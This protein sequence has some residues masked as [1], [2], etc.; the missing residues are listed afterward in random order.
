MTM[1]LK[2]KLSTLPGER[3]VQITVELPATAFRDLQSYVAHP[4]SQHVHVSWTGGET[5]HN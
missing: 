4:N 2:L 1:K 3:P 5:C